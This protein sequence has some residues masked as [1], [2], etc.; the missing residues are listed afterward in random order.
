VED[1]EGYWEACVA[2]PIAE[3]DTRFEKC[4]DLKRN[5]WQPICQTE[6]AA[7][8]KSRTIKTASRKTRTAVEA[9]AG[10][11]VAAAAAAAEPAKKM[12]PSARQFLAEARRMQR[13]SKE[14]SAGEAAPV[15]MAIS[16][17]VKRQAEDDDGA[18]EASSSARSK[19]SRVSFGAVVIPHGKELLTPVHASKREKTETG[20]EVFLTPVRRSA[21]KVCV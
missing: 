12:R 8:R 11:A 20:S 3:V 13:Q 7:P 19:A 10:D 6:P 18:S 4:D 2:P 9:T 17:A 5:K 15:L 16:A 1:L 21:R 14:P